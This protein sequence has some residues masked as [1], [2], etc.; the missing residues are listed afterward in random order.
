MSFNALCSHTYEVLPNNFH[1][2]SSRQMAW[3]VSCLFVEKGFGRACKC[4]LAIKET[5]YAFFMPEEIQIAKI[6]QQQLLNE[7]RTISW[8]CRKLHWQRKKWYRFVSSSYIDVNDLYKIS[9]LLNH[10]FFHYYAAFLSEKQINGVANQLQ[11]CVKT[12][13]AF[14]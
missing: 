8:L 14:F 10:N 7:G 1:E 6:I 12:D 5:I 9:I 4:K 11:I 2:N 13:T 3:I